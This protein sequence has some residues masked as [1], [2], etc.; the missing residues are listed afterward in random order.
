MTSNKKTPFQVAIERIVDRLGCVPDPSYGRRLE[1]IAGPLHI[2]PYDTWVATRFEDVARAKSLISQG[3]LNPYSGKWNWHFS[4]SELKDPQ[5][6]ARVIFHAL[7]GVLPDHERFEPMQSVNGEPYDPDKPYSVV[8][9]YGYEGRLGEKEC[10]RVVFQPNWPNYL[11]GTRALIHAANL[12]KDGAFFVPGQVGLEDLQSKLPSNDPQQDTPF[13]E[14]A[15][16][17]FTQDEPP[18]EDVSFN[19][20][21]NRCVDVALSKKGWNEKHRPSPVLAEQ[22]A[23]EDFRECV[24]AEA[25]PVMDSQSNRA[26]DRSG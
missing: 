11:F 16:V 25:A 5:A 23:P 4:P 1:T 6:C 14:I 19:E 2:S 24:I 9:T 22:D 20:F 3:T 12:Q 17:Q 21:L 7:T 26:R 10:K 8:L 15:S 13:H 18:T